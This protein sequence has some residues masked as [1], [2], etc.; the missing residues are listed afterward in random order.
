[1]DPRCIPGASQVDARWRLDGSQVHPRCVPGASQVDLRWIQ[2]DLRWISG[3]EK[4]M[5]E[6]TVPE[7]TEDHDPQEEKERETSP[8]GLNPGPGLEEEQTEG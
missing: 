3:A 2:V 6:S 4:R 5:Q 8:P 7:H 1:M